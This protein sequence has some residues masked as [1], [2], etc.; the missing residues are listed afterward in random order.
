MELIL[1]FFNLLLIIGFH[2]SA[3]TK[4]GKLNELILQF[5][6]FCLVLSFLINFIKIYSQN[7]N[8]KSLFIGVNIAI[9]IF[10]IIL[11]FISCK[12]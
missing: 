11:L 10:Y 12:K 1:F 6:V 3:G 5:I 7:E 8:L 2:L 4:N 9:S